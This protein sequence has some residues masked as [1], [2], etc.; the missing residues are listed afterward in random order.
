V[1]AEVEPADW[2]CSFMPGANARTAARMGIKYFPRCT[3]INNTLLKEIAE[4]RARYG[5]RQDMGKRMQDT[6]RG[7]IQCGTYGDTK[8]GYSAVT[9]AIPLPNTDR[10]K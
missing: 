5:D 6:S 4:F 9:N 1:I 3:L 2:A 8:K 10:S 7:V